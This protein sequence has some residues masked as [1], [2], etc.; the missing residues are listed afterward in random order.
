MV[1]HG[2]AHRL[3]ANLAHRATG[4]ILVVMENRGNH[5]RIADL[6]TQFF[7][8]GLEVAD[9]FGGLCENGHLVLANGDSR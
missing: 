4:I 7:H 6:L 9:L 1:I 5:L 3:V 8:G 2:A